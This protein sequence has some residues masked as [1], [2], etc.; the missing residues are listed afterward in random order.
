M[1]KSFK[2]KWW[3]LSTDNDIHDKTISDTEASTV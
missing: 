1:E 2:S 3:I